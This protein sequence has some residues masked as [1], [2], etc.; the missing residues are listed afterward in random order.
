MRLD[1]AAENRESGMKLTQSG[2]NYFR[3]ALVILSSIFLALTSPGQSQPN[4]AGTKGSPSVKAT[5]AEAEKFIAEA[6]KKLLELGVKSNK[7]DWVKS[8]FITDD[9]EYLSADA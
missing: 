6:E 8:N 1:D 3:I 2:G 5:V 9:T 4:G 7:A